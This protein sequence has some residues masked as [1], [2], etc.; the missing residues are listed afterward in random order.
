MIAKKTK[1][2]VG[3]LM[4]VL[5]GAAQAQPNADV[6]IRGGT[7]YDGAQNMSPY[8][9]DVAITG[10][11]ILY[12]GPHADMPA[13]R[14]IDPKGMIVSPGFLDPHTHP[15][16]FLDAAEREARQV[17]AWLAQGVTT[18]FIGVDG[19][20][21]TDIAKDFARYKSQ[22]IG[23]NVASYVGFGTIRKA[24][25]GEVN[26]APTAGEVTREKSLVAKGMCEGALGFSTGLFYVP[27]SYAQTPEVIELAKVAAQRGGIY[28]THTR[29]YSNFT[30]GWRKSYEEA[31][32]IGKEAH[33]PVHLSHIKLIG[34]GVWGNSVEVVKMVQQAQAA[35]VMVSSSQYPY[36]GNGTSITAMFVPNWAM[37][38][39]KKALLQRI[40]N[41]ETLEK[42]K[43]EMAENI[44]RGGGPSKFLFRGRNAAYSGKFLDAVAR[45]WG[46]TPVDAALKVI[47]EGGSDSLI[48]FVM[49]EEDI[50]TFMKQPWNFTDSDGGEGHPREYGTYPLKYQKYVLQEKVIPLTFFIRS[51]TGA[52]ADF[53]G[54]SQRGYLK[55]GY[56]ADVAVINPERYAPK[57]DFSHYDVLAD[58]V[59]DLFVNGKAAIEAGKMTAVLSG[60][61]LP[62]TATAGSCP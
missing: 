35:G 17:P 30:V 41:P 13:Q 46:M 2:G 12:V 27:Q 43:K 24:I 49:S 36:T 39:G 50:A 23:V 1:A 59:V 25:I 28:D 4:G 37:D 3:F 51:S 6:V 5:V 33:M 15:Q 21:S 29:D 8:V 61:P 47:R 14:E 56:F 53:F 48:G 11:K 55:A 10:D 32:T 62:H 9:G 38:G 60:V 57:N 44:E 40:G 22:G 42:I 16:H 58:G 26:R 34:P 18:I 45:D 31:L 19:A 54:I 7:I 52:T 20:G